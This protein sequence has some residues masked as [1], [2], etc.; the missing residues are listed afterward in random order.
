MVKLATLP[1]SI[2]QPISLPLGKKVAASAQQQYATFSDDSH[3]KSPTT[4][5]PIKSQIFET[6]STRCFCEKCKRSHSSLRQNYHQ[7][8]NY[9]LLKLGIQDAFNSIRRD[10]LLRNCL[11]DCPEIFRLA[12]LAYS[13]PT[14]LS[15]N[16]NL[17]WS[18]SGVQQG[19]QSALF[20]FPSLFMT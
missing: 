20:S 13:S 7:S 2:F 14:P 10:I 5:L 4:L 18:D 15:A 9:I 17:I 6:R 19:D 3:L 8:P 12:S 1:V 11:I 16:G